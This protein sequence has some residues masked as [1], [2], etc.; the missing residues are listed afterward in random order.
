NMVGIV[1]GQFDREVEGF[2]LVDL[3]GIA[4]VEALLPDRHIAAMR[5]RMTDVVALLARQ[6]QR[7][8]SRGLGP[9]TLDQAIRH[10]MTLHIEKPDLAC[11]LRHLA[12]NAGLAHGIGC[13]QRSDVDDR[14]PIEGLALSGSSARWIGVHD[15]APDM[16]SLAAPLPRKRLRSSP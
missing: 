9:Q 6:R 16:A 8:E 4:R 11:G 10:A 12:R 3:G 2:L 7:E 14:N 13:E 5:P 15:I 1:L